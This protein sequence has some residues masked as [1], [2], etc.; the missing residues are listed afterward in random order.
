MK[1]LKSSKSEPKPEKIKASY[2]EKS[3]ISGNYTVL[4]EQVEGPNGEVELY[5]VCMETGYQ[6]YWNAWKESNTDIITQLEIQ[7]PN[8]VIDYKK[9]DSSGRV[10]YP[11]IGIS[12]TVALCPY[13]LQH[14][15]LGWAL[16]AVSPVESDSDLSNYT[17][18]K[19]PTTIENETKLALYKLANTPMQTWNLD[20]FQPAFEAYLDLFMHS[21]KLNQTQQD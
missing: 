4:V 21:N 18:V 5:K 10:W 3:P 16:V 6:T 11:M 7:M 13:M 20:E 17:I 15:Q 9:I 8:F 14:N 1:K 2:D 19:I 12:H